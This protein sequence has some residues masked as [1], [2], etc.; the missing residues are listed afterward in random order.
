MNPVT[1]PASL[2]LRDIHLPDAVS[3]WPLAP[4]WWIVIA[5]TILLLIYLYWILFKR[6]K[7]I[8][9]VSDIALEEFR[10]I[11]RDF[12]QHKNKSQLAK[13]L[14]EFLR[15]VCLSLFPRTDAAGLL[16]DEWLGF[17]DQVLDEPEFMQAVQEC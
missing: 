11:Q 16:G 9:P 6:K 8:K 10:Q 4:G 3:W 14:S 13:D 1:D 7:P 15:R 17:L 12:D 2:P 5:L